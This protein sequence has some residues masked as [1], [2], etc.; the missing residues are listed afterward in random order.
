MNRFHLTLL[1]AIAPVVWGTTYIV[2]T[3]L[4]PPGHPLLASLARALP[5]GV[6]AIAL[7]R[8]LPT[9]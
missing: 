5:A 4:L 2:T 1:T 3:E 6:V 9:G 7:T 8:A